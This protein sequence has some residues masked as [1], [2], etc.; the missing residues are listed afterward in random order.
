[1]DTSTS[2]LGTVSETESCL[3][4]DSSLEISRSIA[5]SRIP[6]R[7]P[8]ATHRKRLSFNVSG[9]V[10]V[11]SAFLFDNHPDTL[12]GCDERDYFFDPRR[13][14]Y[15]FDRDPKVFR[16]ILMYYRTGSLHF[17]QDETA[18][19]FE[20]ELT[21]FGIRPDLIAPCCREVYTDNK[22]AEEK[23]RQDCMQP[24][25]RPRS[26]PLAKLWQILEDP[27]NCAAATVIFSVT[28]LFIV[29]SILANAVETIWCLDY[30]MVT[31][32]RCGERYKV[33]FSVIEVAS[34]GVF[35]T[36]YILRLI[37]TPDRRKFLKSLL[38]I[39]DIVSILPFYIALCIPE[40]KELNGFFVTLRIFRVFR[41]FKLSRSSAN[42]RLLGNTLTACLQDLSF[43]LFAL[44]VMVTIFATVMY[45]CDK[46][47]PDSNFHSIP[48]G[49]WFIVVTMTTVGYGDTV[50]ETLAGKLVTTV[51]CLSSIVLLTLPV[52]IIVSNFSAI[53]A[54]ELEA[55]KRK[56]FE[57]VMSEKPEIKGFERQHEHLLECLQSTTDRRFK[58]LKSTE[59]LGDYQNRIGSTSTDDGS[60]DWQDMSPD[61]T[62]NQD[63]YVFLPQ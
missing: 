30:D 18:Q 50:P 19:A 6:T 55:L 36:E 46:G 57:P 15:V 54:M 35:T 31:Y 52:T 4:R 16:Y 42:M 21:F 58:R 7:R 20:D 60:S 27:Y 44:A 14:E 22:E 17:P 13:E 3:T 59:T 10:F 45:Y 5:L 11:T 61:F 49:I 37:A 53:Y 2:S 47:H 12:L 9:T 48:H 63:T 23:Y 39:V 41:V 51:C 62:T 32:V 8:P 24:K 38:S 56:N 34:V 43:L 40:N 25:E 26:G 29:L 1:M 33:T 28:G